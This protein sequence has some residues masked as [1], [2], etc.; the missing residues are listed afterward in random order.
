[1]RQVVLRAIKEFL[2]ALQGGAVPSRR[3]VNSFRAE[4][5]KI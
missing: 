3:G 1:M 5:C 4:L 2:G